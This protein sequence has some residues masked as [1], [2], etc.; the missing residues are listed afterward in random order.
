M[1]PR[2]DESMFHQSIAEAEIDWLVCIELNT[3]ESFRKW[4]IPRLFPHIADVTHIKAW[5][6]VSTADGESDLL[7]LVE[8]A[9]VGRVMALIENK[10][11]A[12]AQPEQYQ[13]YL[14]RGQKYVESEQCNDF[15][16]A[17]L[18]PNKYRSQDS[19]AYPIQIAYEDIAVW[20][21]QQSD[22]RSSY[23]ASIY[24]AAIRKLENAN[25]PDKEITEFRR[26][27]WMLAKT[28]FP[29]LG[30]QE[31][32]P[33]GSGEYWVFM[34]RPRYTLIYKTFKKQFKFIQSVVDLELAGR[35]GDVGELQKKYASVMAGTGIELV[36][37]G[38]SAS[39]RI[40]VPT[41]EPPRFDVEKVRLALAA[42][43]KLEG[44][45]QKV[46]ERSLLS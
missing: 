42:A 38:K 18:S 36:E 26:N 11:K 25:P 24:E 33:V 10:I 12:V 5:R 40:E 44:W 17:L 46:N 16:V 3:S 22:K 31:P 6:S 32:P 45:W 13:R 8:N 37:T 27:V 43:N 4:V 30:I 9:S 23:F 21:A 35:A 14:K 2:E 34:R 28:E 7:W 19:S 41:I 20:Y 39:F 29:E 1:T 15:I